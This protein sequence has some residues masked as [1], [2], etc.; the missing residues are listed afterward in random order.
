[1]R[2]LQ[3]GSE[4]RICCAP[5]TV[6]LYLIGPFKLNTALRLVVL[7]HN[8]PN[9]FTISIPI[10]SALTALNV[11]VAAFNSFK[12]KRFEHRDSNADDFHKITVVYP[13]LQRKAT[14]AVNKN[15][16]GLLIGG[17]LW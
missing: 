15:D 17:S 7:R 10:L 9:A 11:A 1:M 16:C 13:G 14:S 3:S 8:R 12:K 5:T 4:K 2:R 6:Y